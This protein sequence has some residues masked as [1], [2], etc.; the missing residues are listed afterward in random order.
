MKL[1]PRTSPLR[2]RSLFF[3]ALVQLLKQLD[4][5]SRNTYNVPD[6]SIPVFETFE[7]CRGVSAVVWRSDW[8]PTLYTGGQVFSATYFLSKPRQKVE[9]DGVIQICC[10][11]C[12]VSEYGLKNTIL[13]FKLI[14]T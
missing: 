1:V 13:L 9:L 5:L 6:S 4:I 11:L 10:A 14:F 7:F 3:K 2:N 8:I 12:H